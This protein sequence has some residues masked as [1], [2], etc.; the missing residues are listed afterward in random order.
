[1]SL[2]F[3]RIVAYEFYSNAFDLLVNS[4]VCG[5]ILRF[6]CNVVFLDSN[7]GIFTFILF[8]LPLRV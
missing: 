3:I 7:F 5:Y 6:V 8:Q 2:D 1:L 4:T